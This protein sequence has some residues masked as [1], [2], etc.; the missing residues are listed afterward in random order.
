MELKSKEVN[1]DTILQVMK[2]VDWICKEFAH[3]DYSMIEAYIIGYSMDD[4]LLED[5]EDLYTRNFIKGSKHNANRG[6]DVETGIWKNVKFVNYV[7]IYND[8]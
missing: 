3:N 2:Y 7:D 4:D 5:N 6:I 1:K 8:Y